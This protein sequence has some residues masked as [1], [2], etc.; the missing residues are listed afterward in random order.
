M[1]QAP[2][3]GATDLPRDARVRRALQTLGRG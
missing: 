3:G 1:A 2:A